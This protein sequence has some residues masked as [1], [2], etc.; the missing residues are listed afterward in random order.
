MGLT[1]IGLFILLVAISTL[2]AFESGYASNNNY[3]LQ[4]IILYTI[5]ALTQIG[6]NYMIYRKQII[7]NRKILAIVILIVLL[8][9]ALYPLIV[10]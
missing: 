10:R 3:N 6:I 8:L 4:L 7:Q 1:N 2:I 5:T 9:Y